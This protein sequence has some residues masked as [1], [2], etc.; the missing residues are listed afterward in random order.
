MA[1]LFSS[2]PLRGLVRHFVRDER[3]SSIADGPSTTDS[4][5]RSNASIRASDS[6]AHFVS[7]SFIRSSSRLSHNTSISAAL[8][9]GSSFSISFWMD[10]RLMRRS[11]DVHSRMSRTSSK[12]F[13]LLYFIPNQHVSRLAQQQRSHDDG[14]PSNNDRIV[15]P[16]IDVAGLRYYRQSN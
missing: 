10:A 1:G 12:T 4:S 6:T 8:S 2:R 5:P 9:A 15:E 14:Y 13:S 11:L 3:S 16:C 7:I